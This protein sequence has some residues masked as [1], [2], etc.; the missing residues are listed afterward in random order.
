[1]RKLIQL[2]MALVVIATAFTLSGTAHAQS[3]PPATQAATSGALS[4]T[5]LAAST[6]DLSTLAAA[7]KAIGFDNYFDKNGPYT[8]L[9]PTNA[10][11]AAALKALNL[12][13]DKLLADKQTLTRI[14]L[15]HVL[16]GSLQAAAFS[17][18]SGSKVATL[19]WGGTLTITADAKSVKFN[20]ATVTTADVEASNGIVHVID[21]VLVPG[22]E[23]VAPFADFITF[24]PGSKD[25]LTIAGGADNLKTLVAAVGAAPSVGSY[26][27]TKGASFT[28]FAPNDAAFTAAFTALKTTPDAF[29][30]DTATLTTVLALHVIPWPYTSKVLAGY[31][32]VLTGTVLTDTFLRYKVAGGKISIGGGINIVTAD[33]LAS[34][35]IV[36]II[37]DVLIPPSLTAAK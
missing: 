1:M 19:L 21:Q 18:N 33:V 16:P 29:L 13:A 34:N 2:A 3:T 8:V 25:L 20:K 23:T 6:P 11:F 30:K 17:K 27:S 15:Y 31:D 10:A 9:A 5:A 7:L 32:G 12:T 4:I 37:D 24:K 28:V 22:D 26:L 36:H 14:L 35:G